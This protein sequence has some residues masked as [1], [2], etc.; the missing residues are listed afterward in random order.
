MARVVSVFVGLAYLTQGQQASPLLSPKLPVEGLSSLSK[1]PATT[2]GG[3]GIG[4]P[5]PPEIPEEEKP[6]N[7]ALFQA[8]RLSGVD[9]GVQVKDLLSQRANVNAQAAHGWSALHL[10]MIESY[11]HVQQGRDPPFDPLPAAKALIEAKADLDMLDGAGRTALFYAVK[12]NSS[13]IVE[14]F[15]DARELSEPHRS[16]SALGRALKDGHASSVE[17]M[18]AMGHDLEKDRG[19]PHAEIRRLLQD[20]K[21]DRI[22]VRARRL[23][24]GLSPDELDVKREKKAWEL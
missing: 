7:V 10:A 12:S 20:H 19:V 21:K 2:L 22:P 5:A 18:L 14:L 13:Q 17:A 11:G 15:K 24:E 23:I 9:G 1:P 3:A 8:S 16:P 4:E 6:L